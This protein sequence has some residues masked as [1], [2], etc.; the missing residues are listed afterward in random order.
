MSKF[1]NL[2][3]P[4]SIALIGASSHEEKI[5]YQLLKNI[6]DGCYSG[7]I[8]PVNHNSQKILGLKCYQSVEA[9]NE[10]IDL[11]IIVIPSIMVYDSV[12]ECIKAG[13]QSIIIIS[14][15]FAEIGQ[16]GLLLQEKI[17]K[18]C[19]E[20]S[21]TLLGPNCLGLINT[22]INL[23]AT[24]ARTMPKHGRVSF[25]SQSGAIVSSLIDWS[26]SEAIGFSKV[27]SIGN[28]A[29]LGTTDLL[30][31]LYDDPDTDVVIAYLE[32]LEVDDSLNVILRE[33][34]SKKPTIVLFGGKTAFGAKA[35][36]SHTGAIAN[37]YLMIRTYLQQV[38]LISVDG[39]EDFL[40]FT[41]I[42]SSYRRMDGERIA[43]ITNAGGPGIATSDALATAGFTLASLTNN[44]V[45]KLKKVLP[46]ESSVR[47]PVDLLGDASEQFYQESIAIIAD[48]ANVDAIIV[49]LTP[50]SSTRI[51]ETA[52]VIASYNNPKPLLATFVGGE[53]LREAKMIIESSGKPCFSFPE[54]AVHSLEALMEFSKMSKV[55]LK[56]LPASTLTYDPKDKFASLVKAGLPVVEY[57]YHKKGEDIKNITEK[58]SYP[59]VAKVADEVAHKSELGKVILNINNVIELEKA[60]EMID[61]QAIVG[62]MVETKFE[63]F[64]G[65]KKNIDIGTLVIFGTGGIYAELLNDFSYGIAPLSIDR[66]HNMILKTKIGQILNGARNQKTYDLN[67]LAEIIEKAISYVQ[68]YKNIVEI[69]FN[70]IIVDQNSYNM[71]DVRI[72][73][74]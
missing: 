64:L 48:D 20:N 58:V 35:A 12:T 59:M 67:K 34:A 51:K 5:G 45:L 41:R 55:P 30:E 40:L 60:L 42:F 36:S 23:N 62:K 43:I 9:I 19:Q 11:A 38:G 68:S 10:P 53:I 18:L 71:V 25:I 52:S 8:Y 26:H 37:E 66:I 70:P 17:S 61:G 73:K 31:Y 65:I 27:F 28:Q 21:V 16:E 22:E 4:K 50:Q 14:A 29:L 72:I 49:I 33:N 57:F 2:I 47:N 32:T 56:S 44:S 74:S 15:G 7:K 3:N 69:D 24:F 63:L 54:E 1:Q 13:I 39:L 46:K 6:L